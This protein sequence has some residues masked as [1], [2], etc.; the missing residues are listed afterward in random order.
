MN[1]TDFFLRDLTLRGGV[2]P[3]RPYIPILMP[4][5]EGGKLNPTLVITHRLG[6][7]QVSKGY[8]LMDQRK[9][10]AIKVVFSPSWN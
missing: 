2:A 3:A 9:E 10:G 4:L 8:D 5:V 6:L 7:D 1:M